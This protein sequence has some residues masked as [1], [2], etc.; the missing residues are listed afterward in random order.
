MRTWDGKAVAV[1]PGG[2]AGVFSNKPVEIRM[3]EE[4]ARRLS[5]ALASM[6]AVRKSQGREQL[7]LPEVQE[8]LNAINYVFVADPASVEAHRVMEAGK[9][10]TPDGGYRFPSPPRDGRG[11]IRPEDRR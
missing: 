11:F 2:L 3:T 6:A 9:G 5:F 7:L 4:G 8:L 1:S 10:M